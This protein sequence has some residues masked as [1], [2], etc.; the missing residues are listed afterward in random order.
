MLHSREW[1][2]ERLKHVLDLSNQGEYLD[3]ES[4]DLDRVATETSRIVRKYGITWN[5]ESLIPDDPKLLSTIFQA[6]IELACRLGVFVRDTSRIVPYGLEEIQSGLESLPL[7]LTMGEGMDARAIFARKVMDERPPLVWGGSPGTSLPEDL[8][9]RIETSYA[10]ENNIDMLSTGSLA[11]V[12]GREVRTGTPLE[13]MATQRELTLLRRAIKDAGRPGMG[14]MGAESSVSAYGDLSVA[15]PAFLR[16]CDAH[17]IPMQNELKIDHTSLMKAANSIEYGMRNSSLPCIV[18]GGLGGDAPGSA[19]LNIASF[20][21][22]NLVCLADFHSCHPIHIRHVATTTR[23]V[24]WVESVTCQAFAKYAPCIL[25]G[26][27]YPKSGALTKELLYEVAA[28]AIVITVSGGHLKGPASADGLLPNCTGLEARWMGEVGHAVARQGLNMAEANTLVN[29]LIEKY[30]Y[31]FDQ[32]GGNPG[33]TF[34]Q[35]YD[36]ETIQ[37]RL[38][39]SAMVGEVREE[40]R[41]LGLDVLSQTGNK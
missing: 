12:D 8:F 20:A 26:D 40:I 14:L 6:G 21:L 19:V 4:W 3:E 2:L 10:K 5:S 28:N 30:E 38:E 7:E 23:S 15:N 11:T 25:F 17:L 13:L 32:P 41:A 35:A 22:S 1:K 16:P 24:L 36:P 9:L 34:D 33:K 37:P 29:K 18:V 31:I 39:W 27:I